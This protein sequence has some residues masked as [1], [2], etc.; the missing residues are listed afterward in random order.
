MGFPDEMATIL[1]VTHTKRLASSPMPTLKAQQ[2]AATREQIVGNCLRLFAHRGL[3]ATSIAEI[4]S[5]AGLTK[6]AIYWHFESKDALFAAI[7]ALI[8]EEWQRTV[9]ARVREARGAREKL[10]QLFANYA[11]LLTEHPEVCLFL[12]RAT[13][14]GDEDIRAEVRHVF[15]QT[16]RF[17]ARIFE[18][19]KSEGIVRLD[20]ES[21]PLAYA[22]LGALEGMVL[23]CATKPAR[24]PQWIGE[25]KET[26]LARALMPRQRSRKS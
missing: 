12:Q 5:A 25:V 8:K 9:V 23:H 2:S 14:D 19:G 26:F 4:A 22:L 16:T 20:L 10:E 17:I 6:G 1:D 18:E 7:L 3:H 21:Q 13:L 24:V 15:E 11:V